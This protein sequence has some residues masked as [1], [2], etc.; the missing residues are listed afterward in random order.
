[1]VTALA[2]KG[3]LTFCIFLCFI[4]CDRGSDKKYKGLPEYDLNKPQQI[5]LKDELDEISGIFY[6][7][8]DTSV[9]AIN[10]E[11]GFLY[12]I[13]LRDKVQILRWQFS[14]GGD[15][16]DLC[17][18]DSTFYALHSN[19][20]LSVFKVLS[21]D[22]VV[23]SEVKAPFPGKNDFETLYYDEGRDKLILI[24]KECR[25]DTKTA[26][27]AYTYDRTTNNFSSSAVLKI[28]AEEVLK[29]TGHKEKK[30]KPS[31][32]AINPLTKELYILSSVNKALVVADV[33]GKIKHVVQLNP[34]LFK[35]PEGITFSAEGD[36]MISN[37]F[38]EVGAADILV[39]KPKGKVNAK[40]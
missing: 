34:R 2:R 24:C 33:D 16:E 11:A 19:G 28:E 30:F 23:T 10:D 35:Q 3:L 14:D 27:S 36:L 8:K 32:A 15:F 18:V 1:M 20:N 7:P 22:S 37:E 4:G 9:F 39:F 5:K 40:K 17:L 29:K 26:V 21:A 38:A 31:A 13:Y 12:K 6:Y 25:S